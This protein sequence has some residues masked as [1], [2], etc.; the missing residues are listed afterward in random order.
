MSEAML[1]AD[2]VAYRTRLALAEKQRD[3]AQE[4]VQKLMCSLEQANACTG[5]HI[6][7]LLQHQLS[8][9]EKE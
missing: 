6:V 1:R 4:E 3:D 2:I 9:P 8:E 5:Q 7:T